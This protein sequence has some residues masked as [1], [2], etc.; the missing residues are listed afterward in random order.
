VSTQKNTFLFLFLFAFF[1]NSKSALAVACTVDTD[2]PGAQKCFDDSCGGCSPGVCANPAAQCPAF[3][4]P[5]E[6]GSPVCSGYCPFFDNT[7]VCEW[8]TS[9][10]AVASVPEFPSGKAWIFFGILLVCGG[11][12]SYWNRKL[13]Y[14]NG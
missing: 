14:K 9:C 4:D 1:L 2:C 10:V 11:F 6:C 5:G 12:F 3:G 13:K 7:G 8:T